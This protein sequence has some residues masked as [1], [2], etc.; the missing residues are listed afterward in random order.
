M[1]RT[2][3]TDGTTTITVFGKFNFGCYQDFHRALSGV[4]AN[5]YV[6]DLS[7]TTYV[8]S[9]ALGMLLLVRERVGDDRRRVTLRVG[10][11]QPAEVLRL[12]NFATLFTIA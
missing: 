4:A 8:D 1:I 10:K 2:S 12:A 3:S 6:I 5:T 11:G 7:E 9:A